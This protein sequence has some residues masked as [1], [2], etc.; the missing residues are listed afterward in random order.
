MTYDDARA[1]ILANPQQIYMIALTHTAWLSLRDIQIQ[2]VRIF[3]NSEYSHTA[4]LWCVAGR[5]FVI[6]AVEPLVRIVPLSTIKSEGFYL[7]PLGGELTDAALTQWLAP[8]GVGAYSKIQA[9]A[10]QL[11]LLNIG[12][13]DL[14]ECSELVIMQA[15][16]VGID[17]GS[18][19]TPSAVV[20]SA[21]KLGA[22][23]HYVKGE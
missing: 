6:E 14:W 9:I 17:L 13:D 11:N 2:S 1:L 20:L 15:R 12:V 23:L 22:P 3:T 10:A 16:A 18:K 21:Q 19:A 5:V 4:L 7:L 8:V